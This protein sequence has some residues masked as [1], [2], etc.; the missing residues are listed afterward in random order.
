MSFAKLLLMLALSLIFSNNAFP[1]DTLPP[2][3]TNK[4][5]DLHDDYANQPRHDYTEIGTACTLTFNQHFYIA[6]VGAITGGVFTFLGMWV[7]RRKL[8]DVLAEKEALDFADT[9]RKTFECV[10]KIDSILIPG[11]SILLT[12]GVQI[13]IEKI[14]HVG[15]AA[16]FCRFKVEV[17]Y[18]GNLIRGLIRHSSIAVVHLHKHEAKNGNIDEKEKEAKASPKASLCENCGEETF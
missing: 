5:N 6:I 4:D 15:T 14:E 16:S 11:R 9:V 18:Q 10:G 12:S 17:P 1:L 2:F 3:H 8:A 13:Y 7:F